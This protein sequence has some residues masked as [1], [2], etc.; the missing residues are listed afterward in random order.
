MKTKLAAMKILKA[1]IFSFLLTIPG[2]TFLIIGPSQSEGVALVLKPIDPIGDL[3]SFYAIDIPWHHQELSY[4]CGPACLKMVFGCHGWDIDESEIRNVANTTL[5]HGGTKTSDLVR[6]A[7]FSNTSDSCGNPA[8][9][10]Y[11]NKW[12]GCDSVPIWWSGGTD[13]EQD[14]ISKDLKRLLVREKTLI[15]LMWYT[16]LKRYGHYRVLRGYDDREGVF[17]F[18]DPLRATAYS[19]SHWNTTYD[20]LYSK[21]WD[22]LPYYAQ[23][24]NPWSV[25][26][27]FLTDPSPSSSFEVRAVINSGIDNDLRFHVLSETTAMISLPRDYELVSGR[28]KVEFQLDSMGQTILTWQVNAPAQIENSD[29]VNVFVSGSIS[30]ESY[31]YPSY[32]DTIGSEASLSFCDGVTPSI[33]DITMDIDGDNVRFKANVTD[34]T[35]FNSVKLQWR[36]SATNWSELGMENIGNNIW[37]S[38]QYIPFSVDS[39]IIQVRVIAKD[40]CNNTSESMVFE[41]GVES[42]PDITVFIIAGVILGVVIIALIII[43]R[44]RDREPFHPRVASR[45]IISMNPSITPKVAHFSYPPE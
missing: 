19:G 39:D 30:D 1:L 45:I 35:G 36:K 28:E 33:S 23:I 3:P 14:S 26:L 42:T 7:H 38:N 22:I 29:S 44:K 31:S 32:T 18:A 6:A 15:L 4:S 25:S 10:G 41:S 27:D 20:E 16:G 8:I 17:I 21:Y 43:I 11:S 24:V 5:L 9:Q 40:M 13:E 34:K 37:Q 12:Y 2:P